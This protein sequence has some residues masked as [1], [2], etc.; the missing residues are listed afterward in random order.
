MPPRI[1]RQSGFSQGRWRNGRGV[2][3]DIVS[4]P[5]QVGADFAWRLAIARIDGDVPFSDYPGV[6]RVFTLLDGGGLDLAVAGLGT[7][8]VHEPFVPA[9]FPG[10]ADTYCTLLA[11]P[12]RALNLFVLRNIWRADVEVLRLDGRATVGH[13]GPT[14]LYALRGTVMCGQ[15]TIAEGDA[16]QLD[17]PEP[18]ESASGALLYAAKLLPAMNLRT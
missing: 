17:A 6:D 12:C 3:W 9:R 4:G 2:S 5:A 13:G 18:V 8:E 7:L 1:F 10:D 14:L 16:A 15:T 11:G